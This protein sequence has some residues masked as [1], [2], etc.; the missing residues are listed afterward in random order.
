[1]HVLVVDDDG[2]IRSLVTRVLRAD[3]LDVTEAPDGE[4]ALEIA[5]KTDF[6]MVLCDINMGRLN[7]FDVLRAF[8]E[9]I[10]PGAD[11]VLM[12]GQASL[13]AALEAVTS[14][15]QDYIVKP[16][17]IED[18]TALAQNTLERRR[19]MHDMAAEAPEPIPEFEGLIGRSRP[20]IEVFKTV[21][22]IAGTDLPVLI[23]GESGTGK[24]VIARTIHNRS[25]RSA[26]SFAAI[27]CGALTDTLLDAEL[28]GHVKGSFTGAGSDRRGLFEEANGGTLLLDEV[29]ETSAAFQVKLLRVLQE[30]EVRRVGA[31]TY[32]KINVR[33]IATT[34]R[35]PEALVSAGFFR[36]DL[37]Y[38]LNVIS[39]HLPPLRER[40]EDIDL[41]IWGFL[42]QFRPPGAPPVRIAPEALAKLKAY[43]WPGNVRELRHTIQR[44]LALNSGAVVRVKD[45]PEKVQNAEGDLDDLLETGAPDEAAKAAAPTAASQRTAATEATA[46]PAAGEEGWP[47]L[48]ELE[49]RYL[50]RVLYHTC[51][52]AKRAAEILGVDRKTLSRMV[53]R[54]AIDIDGVR[55][56]TRRPGVG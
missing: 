41:M 40:G 34:N 15:A 23:S 3:G 39:L 26:K 35:D 55:R 54:H 31:N 48:S 29:T 9:E 18:L 46:R 17:R 1:M 2:A 22:R 27:N 12:T 51:G 13:E 37:L 50:L 33:I 5:R 32:H 43:A 8:K 47:P 36:E 10:Q 11:F 16:F 44:I 21:G 42:Q 24:E 25:P 53:E 49:R 52:N 4:T 20:M 19:L 56:D 14:G 30:S 45:L 7:G 28:F 38:R 6:D